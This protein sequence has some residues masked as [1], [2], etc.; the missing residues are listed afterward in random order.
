MRHIRTILFTALL[1]LLV[2]A[3]SAAAQKSHSYTS[4]SMLAPVS[5]A[6]GYPNPGG[7]AVV[8]GTLMTK[9]FGPGVLTDTVTIMGQPSPNTLTLGGS[10]VARF[11]DGTVRSTYT[12][13]VTIHEDGSQTIVAN[14]RITRGSGRYSGASGSYTF[15]G[16][17]APGSNVITGSSTG[18]IVF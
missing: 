16:T 14:G 13:T 11:N 18:S 10:E 4:T 9:P 17:T 6:N 8:T 2:A 15:T 12:G 3:P 7:F 1:A 5:T